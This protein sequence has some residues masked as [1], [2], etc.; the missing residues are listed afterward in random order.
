M[1]EVKTAQWC[2]AQGTSHCRQF[3]P[4]RQC[5]TSKWCHSSMT[6]N[7]TRWASET[8]RSIMIICRSNIDSK[9]DVLS[10]N[11]IALTIPNSVFLSQCI[12]LKN[13]TR[14]VFLATVYKLVPIQTQFLPKKD[15]SQIFKA[16]KTFV[17]KEKSV[18]CIEEEVIHFLLCNTLFQWV[19]ETNPC[20]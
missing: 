14:C 10:I 11:K 9:V 4:R 3:H 8:F 20:F 15:Q 1:T 12:L 18:V 5:Y 19:P 6:H 17:K 2:P 13:I 16:C 7:Y